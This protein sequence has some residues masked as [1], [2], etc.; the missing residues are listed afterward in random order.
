MIK[1]CQVDHGPSETGSSAAH[2]VHGPV[3][4]IPVHARRRRGVPRGLLGGLRAGDDDLLPA[5]FRIDL[6]GELD[7]E[8]LEDLLVEAEVALDLGHQRWPAGEVQEDVAALGELPDLVGQ[9]VPAPL[10][11]LEDLSPIARHD[12]R[13]LLDDLLQAVILALGVD[14]EEDLVLPHSASF[15]VAGPRGGAL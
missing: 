5:L 12:A 2:V 13:E 9:F 8:E 10:V 11:D 3:P 1:A 15:W 14:D 7:G 6:V 4:V